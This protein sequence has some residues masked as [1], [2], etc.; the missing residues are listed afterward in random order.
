MSS[1]ELQAL[2]GLLP[3]SVMQ[4]GVRINIAVIGL[5]QRSLSHA[6]NRILGDTDRWDLVAVCDTDSQALD[7]FGARYPFVKCYDSV[8]QL[9][10]DQR[11][12]NIVPV[13]CAYVAIPHSA[14]VV[15]LPLLLGAR[16]HVLKEKPAADT[17]E[18][19]YRFQSLAAQNRIRLMTASQSRYGARFLRIQ[20]LMPLI[21]RV[22]SV[23]GTRKIL[24]TQ[25][26]IGWRASKNCGAMS[27]IGWHLIDIVL[28][29]TG[30]SSIPDILFT[31]L[32][33]MRTSQVYE[34]EDTAH[35]V[36]ESSQTYSNGKTH[37]IFYS[38]TISRIGHEKTDELVFTGENG[39]LCA[40]GEDVTIQTLSAA[41]G[42]VKPDTPTVIISEFQAMLAAFHREILLPLPSQMYLT[43]SSLDVLVTGTIEGAY[44]YHHNSSG[45]CSSLVQTISTPL[46]TQADSVKSNSS[47]S[48]KLNFKLQWPKIHPDV[49]AAVR[50]QLYK[51]ISIYDNG[52]VFKTFEVEFKN[53]HGTPNFFSLLHNSGS[54]ALQALYFAAQLQPGDEVI[55][56]VYTFHATCSPAMH[57]GICPV[58]CDILDNGNI[59]PLAVKRAISGRTKAVVVT[60]MWGLPCDMPA[61]ISMLEEYPSILLLEDCSHAHGAQIDGRHVGTF[62]DGAAWSLQGQKVVSGGEGGIVMTKHAEFHYRQLLWGHYNKRCK[63]EIPPSHPLRSYSLTGVGL[64]HRAHPLAIAV[65]LNQLRKL[66]YFHTVKTRFA[67]QMISVLRAIPFLEMPNLALSNNA[68]S[69]P[70]WYAFVLRFKREKAPNGLCREIFVR[71]LEEAGLQDVDIPKSTGLLFR[72]PLFTNPRGI[73]AH[74]NFGD[75]TPLPASRMQFGNAQRFY[76]EAIKLPVFGEVEDEPLLDHYL[77]TIQLVAEKCAIDERDLP[78]I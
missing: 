33:A 22:H 73:L 72:E 38:L 48:L 56:P 27:D 1:L 13:S 65:A 76:D 24:V 66:G 14:Y 57:F 18:E 31:K 52:G 64:K 61:I 4:N 62:G 59:C 55:F 70:A 47:S 53:F 34:C 19:L 3:K 51:D 7:Q 8:Q 30:V 67:T 42:A 58:F 63:L 6:V 15:V 43:C 21:G 50:V 10:D 44:S 77:N 60:H 46:Q 5:G 68:N 74:V 37:S 16:I 17:L 49:E 12:G 26:G 2:N 32:L 54:N 35:L 11:D 28:G 69:A 9:I 40:R 75:S 71:K 78:G 41:A 45:K 29:L 25:L 20:Q 39:V 23:V 36:F